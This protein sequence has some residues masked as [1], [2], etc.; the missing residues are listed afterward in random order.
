MPL[1]LFLDPPPKPTPEDPHPDLKPRVPALSFLLLHSKSA[2][3]TPI[4]FDLSIPPVC[5]NPDLPNEVPD[6]VLS[7]RGLERVKTIWSPIHI[8]ITIPETLR[9]H[10]MQEEDIEYVILSHL[11]WDHIGD[12]TWF[13]EAKYIIGNGGKELLENGYPRDPN[14]VFRANIL[15]EG[16]TVVLPAIDTEDAWEPLGPFPHAYDLFSDGSLYIIDAPGHLPGHINA[17]ARIAPTESSPNNWVYF[18]GDSA[19][20]RKLLLGEAKIAVLRDQ[21][22]G[23]VKGC[24][25]VNKEKAEE[26][27]ARIREL[28]AMDGVD[29]VGVRVVL[30]HDGEWYKE[31]RDKGVFWPGKF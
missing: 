9:E 5:A 26:H 6:S 16:R 7:P 22:T 21:E 8:P 17:L 19:H 10:G 28:M 29:G 24:A 20:H 25:H 15:P 31:N 2:T 1:E 4:I 30:A 14:S 13:E 3:R 12:P 11:H 27:I 18:G 23:E